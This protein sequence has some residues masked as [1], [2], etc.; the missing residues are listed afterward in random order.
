MNR[1]RMTRRLM[2]RLLTIALAYLIVGSAAAADLGHV[3]DEA[4]LFVVYSSMQ[5]ILE[6]DLDHPD[7]LALFALGEQAFAI[8][9]PELFTGY[10]VKHKAEAADCDST[11]T[12][13]YGHADDWHLIELLAL[14]RHY[15]LNPRLSVESRVSSYVHYYEW[16]TPGPDIKVTPI[17]DEKAYVYV[18]EYD[19]LFEFGVDED[20][21]VLD[22][23]LRAYAQKRSGHEDRH[24]LIRGSWYVPLYSAAEEQAGYRPLKEVRVN[25]GDHYLVN[26]VLPENVEAIVKG[27]RDLA[28]PG[29]S[30]EVKDIWVNDA[31]FEYLGGTIL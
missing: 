11:R 30:V 23:F 21:S 19:A 17:D 15:G 4:T 25:Y 5:Y 3:R 20:V 29:Y 13:R 1:L 24:D 14:M 18:K 6:A 28:G 16:G 2:I 9:D 12:V 10:S 22:D 7:A 26:Y 31:F 27:L 8:L